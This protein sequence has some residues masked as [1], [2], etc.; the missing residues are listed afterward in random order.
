C[1]SF[2]CLVCR[3]PPRSTL[4][5]YRRSS[6]LRD[7]VEGV[8][9]DGVGAVLPGRLE[10]E[11]DAAVV[12]EREALLG[13]RRPGEVAAEPLEARAIAAVERD[14]RM[15]VDPTDLGPRLARGGPAADGLSERGR[16]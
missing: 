16:P 6:D 14:L 2:S 9:Q 15:H 12:M 11:P 7:E 1:V 4:F 10:R 3:R 8:E 5:P 13:E